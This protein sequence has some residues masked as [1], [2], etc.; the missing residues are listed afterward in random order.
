MASF[1]WV[2]RVVDS[3]FDHKCKYSLCGTFNGDN[4]DR[5]VVRLQLL[6]L[7]S[8]QFQGCWLDQTSGATGDWCGW[9]EGSAR[10]AQC[11]LVPV[12]P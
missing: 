3:L 12:C 5:G 7:A 1:H 6:N 4:G 9:R 8:E 2:V 10:L 11:L